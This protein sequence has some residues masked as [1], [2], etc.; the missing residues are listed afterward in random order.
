[1][2]ETVGDWGLA[3]AAIST[4]GV[5]LVYLICVRWWT[6]PLGRGIAAVF[7]SC[8]LVIGIVAARLFNIPL[9]GGVLWWRAVGYW[10][11]G[12]TMTGGMCT[13]I[14]AQFFAPRIKWKDRP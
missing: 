8:A 11:L 10:V 5:M 4:L 9:P 12:T 14:W 13:F 6:D 1:M 3:Y 7:G 2:V